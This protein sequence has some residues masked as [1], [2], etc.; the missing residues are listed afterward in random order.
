MQRQR[1]GKSEASGAP[2]ATAANALV[3]RV[4]ELLDTLRAHTPLP[5]NARETLR[6]GILS[7]ARQHAAET[8]FATITARES[9]RGAKRQRR[10]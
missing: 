10:P 2:P 4:D 6:A 5:D 7:L 8:V 3:A 9:T 1:E